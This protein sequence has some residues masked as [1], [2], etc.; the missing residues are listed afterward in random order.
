MLEDARGVNCQASNFCKTVGVLAHGKFLSLSEGTTTLTIE[1][2]AN[3]IEIIDYGREGVDVDYTQKIQ[4]FHR[5]LLES[6]NAESS[7][8]PNNLRIVK[9]QTI[10]QVP[11]PSPITQLLGIEGSIITKCSQCKS[12][13]EKPY[14]THT[15]DMLYPLK[16]SRKLN[17]SSEH[18]LISR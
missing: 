13:R 18:Y 16:V 14:L 17:I 8:Y 12:F 11:P 15:L 6:L 9:P 3:A 1:I 2:E 10:S 7:N 4:A 5:F